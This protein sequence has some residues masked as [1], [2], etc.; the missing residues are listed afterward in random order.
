M[1]TKGYPVITVG[2]AGEQENDEYDHI[3]LVVGVNSNNM[4]QYSDED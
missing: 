4:G 1:I 2:Y 3:Y